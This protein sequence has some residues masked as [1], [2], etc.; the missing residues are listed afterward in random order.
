MLTSA[1]DVI[2]GS[3][4]AKS[5]SG[6]SG[7]YVINESGRI[8]LINMCPDSAL[9]NQAVIGKPRLAHTANAISRRTIGVDYVQPG[10]NH[11]PDI[12]S[13]TGKGVVIGIIDTGIDPDHI[14]FHHE[15]GNLRVSRYIFTQSSEETSDGL[16]HADIYDTPE[17]I[18]AA[19]PDTAEGGHGTHT[20]A[21]AAGSWM[22]NDYRG[23]APEAELFFVST[24]EA[25]YDDEIIYG[26]RAVADYAESIG[27]PAVMSLS[28]G[29]G[30]GPRDGTSPVGLVSREIAERGHSIVFAAGNDGDRNAAIIRNFGVDT[31]T[32]RSMFVKYHKGDHH[33]FNLEAWSA[34]ERDAEIQIMATQGDKVLYT[35]PWI[36]I[37]D[38]QA[39]NG[40]L[41][42]LSENGNNDMMPELRN[43]FVGDIDLEMGIY[44]PNGKFYIALEGTLTKKIYT[45]TIK[46]TVGFA[47]RSS[48]GADMRIY[49]SA[50]Y[51]VLGSWGNPQFTDGISSENISDFAA[52][53]YTISAGMLNA[54]QSVITMSGET[55]TLQTMDFGSLNDP[56]RFSS[57]GTTWQGDILPLVLAPGSLVVSALYPEAP[58]ME[59]NYVCDTVVN[60][61]RYVWG[62]DSGTSMATP[63]VAGIIALWKE[64]V[65]TL[66]HEQIVDILEQSSN[67]EICSRFPERT[68]YGVIDAYTGLRYAIDK[69]SNI[70]TVYTDLPQ[71][72]SI[73]FID[74]KSSVE[75]EIE[76]LLPL[77]ILD[78]EAAFYALDGR[79]IKTMTVNGCNFR[80]TLPAVPGVYILRVSGNG[81]TASEKFMV[82]P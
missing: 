57:Y 46:P 48:S 20:A 35:G 51:N 37:A 71:R 69:Y 80:I 28:L 32:V 4:S 34:D 82:T 23:M 27:K 45:G 7:V 54:T 42:L 24:G 44:Q 21:T 8:S 36:K 77:K 61:E 11:K 76:C 12:L 16:F 79:K 22:G 59:A 25:I 3:K 41:V 81:Y 26:M 65:P 58:G 55:V 13:Y 10:T 67:V 53:P 43:Y 50:H 75:S 62:H 40:K 74:G 47:V 72:L 29:S 30:S 52:S 66:T 39:F 49:S 64:A 60:G 17:A 38:T 1:I 9:T 15:N 78:A 63:M 5:D 68:A 19:P 73:R 33:Y 18:S 6:M 70:S 14:T 56:N 2:A 31:T